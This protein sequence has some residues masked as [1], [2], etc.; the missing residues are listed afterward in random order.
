MSVINIVGLP[1]AGKS[2][3]FAD[4]ILQTLRRNEKFFQKSGITRL[5][6]TNIAL[7][8]HVTAK[9]NHFIRY[10]TDRNSLFLL[11][12]C[13]VFIDEIAGY[14]NSRDWENLSEETRTWL[15]M[16]EHYG[17]ELFCNTQN[18]KS[19]EVMFRRLTTELIHINKLCGN[20]RPSPT[21]P[22]IKFV[23]GI[24]NSKHVDPKC[25]D[26]E[27][28]NFKYSDMIGS[29]H[30]ITRDKIAL[31]NTRQDLIFKSKFFAKH[32]QKECAQCSW[33]GELYHR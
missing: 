11:R 32:I 14:F 30:L 29:F 2:I 13:D 5:V 7:S 21:R 22:P 25:F 33:K 31:Y 15:M 9:Y 4:Y 20:R 19:I 18:W 24:I 26:E 3:L 23:W 12:D 10:W 17:I 28:W 16:H 8:D 27:E 1:G 6:Y